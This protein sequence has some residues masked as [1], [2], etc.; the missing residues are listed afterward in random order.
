MAERLGYKSHGTVQYHLKRLGLDTR[1]RSRQ[2]RCRACAL[3]KAGFEQMLASGMTKS[4]I[5]S[6]LGYKTQSA[7]TYHLHRLGISTAARRGR[8]ESAAT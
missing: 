7:V 1:H 2:C 5:A 3:G 6:R 8:S 4:E